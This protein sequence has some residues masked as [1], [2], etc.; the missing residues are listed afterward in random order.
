MVYSRPM[1][2]DA[3]TL[4]LTEARRVVVKVGSAVLTGP[5]GLNLAIID[6]LAGELAALHDAGRDVVLV[7][8]GAVAAGRRRVA[9]SLAEGLNSPELHDLPGRQAASAVG[10]GRLMHAYDEALGRRGKV[11]AQ[12]LLTRDGLRLRKRFLNARNTLQRLLDWRVIPI[13]NENDTVAVEEIFGDND[14][15]ASM[16][17]GLVGADL[18]V[19]LTSAAGVFDKNPDCHPDARRLAVIDD[20]HALDLANL[21]DGKSSVGSGGM[22]SKLLAAQRAAQL[23]VPTLILSGRGDFSL[24]RALDDPSLGTL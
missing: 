17:L 1:N 6:H 21:C 10:Q 19:N 14:T 22:H 16:A 4:R 13:I 24:T 2:V 8:S 23:G 20:I 12:V 7:S 3:S 9:G 15:L 11:I 18:F 5:D